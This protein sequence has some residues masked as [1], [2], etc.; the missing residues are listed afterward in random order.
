M[1]ENN[2][3][4][5]IEFLK[6]F[7]R[8]LKPRFSFHYVA[9]TTLFL[10]V[11]FSTI[12]LVG[13]ATPNP[14]H[15][16]SELGDGVFVFTNSQTTTPYTYTF[17]AA[18][19]TVLTTNATVTIAQGGT[20]QTSIPA[21]SVWGA[22][23]AN[24]LSAITSTS[25]TR[26][27]TNTSGT[28]TWE[29]PASGMVYPGAGIPNSTGSAWGTSYT[30]TGS[31]T[32]VA[33]QTSPSFTTPSLGVAT[34]TSVD[35]GTTTLLGSRALTVDTGGVFNIDIGSASGDDF[36][37]DTNKL[38]VEG[39]TGNVGIG[40][41][42]PA[43]KLD[44]YGTD[45][46]GGINTNIGLNFKQ[47]SAPDGT[48]L[49]LS[50]T[51]GT[52]LEIGEYYYHVTYYTAVGE[53]GIS[54]YKKITTTAGNQVVNISNIPISSDG[55]VVGRKIY[56]NKVGEGSSYG[57]LI[58]TI[59]DNTTTT[60]Q[61]I[62]PDSSIT[63]S[64][65]YA[66]VNTTN[67]LVT[68][69][70]VKSMQLDAN[71]TIFGVGAGG[72]LTTGMVNTLIGAYAG[73]VITTGNGNTLIGQN[74]GVKITTGSQNIS[75]GE[76]NLQS[77]TTGNYNIAVG[78]FALNTLS[79]AEH[80]ISIGYAA[81]NKSNA[82]GNIFIGDY[83]GQNTTGTSNLG[84]GVYSLNSNTTGT[85]NSA[86]GSQSLY[87]NTGGIHNTA[88]GYNSLYANITGGYNT[89]L[90]YGS[91][92]YIS[93]GTTGRT[94]G[95]Y[96]LYLGYN[97]KASADGTTNEIVIGYNAIGQG[98]NSV[99]LGSSSVTKTILNGNVGIGTT[100][101]SYPLDVATGTSFTD[102][103]IRTKYALR[104]GT[105]GTSAAPVLFPFSGSGFSTPDP[106]GRGL[107]FYSYAGTAGD[108]GIGFSG[109]NVTAT[110][111]VNTNATFSRSFVP[112]SGTGLYTNLN[113]TG[114][115]NQTGG[116]NGI[117]RGLYI[118]P[119]LTS[120]ADWRS[121]DM[122]NNSGFGIYQSGASAKNYFAG[123][124]GIGTT[125]PGQKL[126]VNGNASING[127]FIG[128]ATGS[129][130]QNIALGNSNLQLNT[131]GA[132]NIGIG[133]T[134]LQAN[135]TGSDNT[136]IGITSLNIN[137]TGERNIAI[138]S[139]SLIADDQSDNIGI[140]YQVGL[141]GL[142][143]GQNILIGNDV[144]NSPS[145]VISNSVF[146]GFNS[147]Y[148][149]AGANNIF[150][151]SNS[152]YYETGSNKLIIDNLLRSSEANGRSQA[153]IYGISNATPANQILSLGGGGKVGIGTISPAQELDVTGNTAISGQTMLGLTSVSTNAKLSLSNTV[154]TNGSSTAIAGIHGDYTFNNGGSSGYVQVGNR[155]VFNNAPT[156]NSNTMV[157][158]I[159]RTVDNTTLANLV[160]GLDITSNAGS[161]TAGTNTGLRASG[162]TFGVQ[163]ITSGL[164]G[165]VSVPAA[166]YG[167][168]TGTTNGDILR[169]FSNS[170]TSAPSLATFYHDTSTFTGTGLLMDFATGSGTFS[171][172]FADFQRNNVSQF[173]ITNTGVVSMGL[174]STA[175]TSAVCSSL[176]NGTAPTSG[177]A[178]EIR[179]CSNTPVAD[180]AEMYPVE[181]GI[182][183][184]D[185]VMIGSEM[186]N[187]Y[188][189]GQNGAINWNKV[190][191]QVTK[192]VRS[193]EPH[194]KNVVG[195]VSNNYNDF[196]STGYNIKNEDNPMPVALSGRVPVKISTQSENLS[197]GDY[198]T[199]SNDDGKAMKAVKS[200][201]VIGKVL[202]DWDKNSGKEM[203]MIFIEPG[204]HNGI[205]T[206][207][208]MGFDMMLD[209]KT[210]DNLLAIQVL[211]KLI[212][213]K[214]ENIGAYLSEIFTDR[215]IAG[216]EIITPD[217]TAGNISVE[218]VATFNG[219]VYFNASLDFAKSVTFNDSVEFI[220]PPLFNK[221]TAGFA[222]IKKDTKEVRIDFESPYLA[223]PVVNI[224]V[225]FEKNKDEDDEIFTVEDYFDE[226]I[227]FVVYDKDETGFSIILNKNAP[228]D[229]S[230]SWIALAVRDPQIFESVIDG[231]KIEDT[232][233][234][235]GEISNTDN[236]EG[237]IDDI[238]LDENNN[239]DIEIEEILEENEVE[240][241]SDVNEIIDNN[242]SVDVGEVSEI[243]EEV[244]DTESVNI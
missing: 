82:Y 175:A 151:G 129:G 132:R 127:I 67:K 23:S 19:S 239:T 135:T 103:G 201:F 199:T 111:G 39:D 8:K 142:G 182:E 223:T 100:S 34:A 24:T 116:A 152:G 102:G 157:G 87:S 220:L 16:W 77:A 74:A 12:K 209:G 60:Y 147:G 42:S 208:Y 90:G 26:V 167:E 59:A 241:T 130:L 66:K 115:I 170:V 226:E 205:S 192:L 69:N 63:T 55:T 106:A 47:V 113:L 218:N 191:G 215:L 233:E 179:D 52:S 25:G 180:Y 177:V 237:N 32:V 203:V 17:P 14:G 198:I 240:N 112:T 95:D 189:V 162:A 46:A 143:G 243:P 110:S 153:L 172:N 76:G 234:E 150:L 96:G 231:L 178:Y 224:S 200:G 48:T 194:Q 197:A 118:N 238:I 81:G 154:S 186:I 124:V 119:N 242:E 144:A 50:T 125:T 193:N 6:K 92:R 195:I 22:N 156:T 171:G 62:T 185:I 40:T 94:T 159:I 222:I 58:A 134:A 33:L 145:G 114:I 148:S 174:G 83:S 126:D 166:L 57:S 204:F 37:V 161:N 230:F 190:K 206:N 136:A 176:A 236:T 72:S 121:I 18:N 5:F 216:A 202:E 29:V 181:E 169:L 109:E 210:G 173:R 138:G 4:K 137:E 9:Y 84:Y 3:Q 51:T 89:A 31:G 61:D 165:G 107:G 140:G 91:G 104:F 80:N 183:Y 27:L 45:S 78:F 85:Y 11:I 117:S 227:E 65:I 225:T 244:G 235:I 131:N 221:D 149:A 217:M 49:S 99:M 53:T 54:S 21:G 56:R 97:T 36:T 160:R 70:D 15:P 68:V 44:V 168:N 41:T 214:E 188:D 20:G 158:E 101:P 64:Y 73:K 2:N 211:E 228:E 93:D 120:A 71:S 164:A 163:G 10:L 38:V 128:K 79:N 13:A 212:A 122:A 123:K 187:T 232:N 146:L 75:L 229:I 184:G 139:S 219:L 28:I 35:F 98:S 86:I 7:L 43:Y 207:E 30:T 213:E 1:S 105:N 196:S 155:F 141:Y 88:N 133:E 108:I